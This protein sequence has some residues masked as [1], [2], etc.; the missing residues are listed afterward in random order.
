MNP[1]TFRASYTILN[2]WNSGNWEMAIKYYFKLESFTTR[3]MADGRDRHQVYDDHIKATKTLP[4]EFGKIKLIDPKPEEKIVV[5]VYP[6]LN[7]VAKIDCL[8]IPT[9]YE[10]KTGAMSSEAYSS[11]KQHGVYGVV[12]TYA[13]HYVNKAEIYRYNP[14]KKQ[15]DVSIVWITKRLLNDSFNWIETIASEMHDYFESNNLYEK[16]GG[17][18]IGRVVQNG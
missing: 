2:T 17:N 16:Y 9:I 13:G 6:W 1:H 10:F 12:C 4:E 3:A 7:I 5:K 18:L 11:H 14:A 15:S 8:D